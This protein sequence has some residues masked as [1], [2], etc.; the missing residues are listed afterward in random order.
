MSKRSNLA[1]IN[2]DLNALK[3]EPPLKKRTLSVKAEIKIP[4]MPNFFI[5]SDGQSIPVQAVTE[6]A[7]REIGAA[8]TEALVQ[9]AAKRRK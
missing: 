9:H 6:D 4:S 7:L 3:W 1:E 5:M 2:D 8:W